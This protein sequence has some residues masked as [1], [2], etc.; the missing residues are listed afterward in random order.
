MTTGMCEGLMIDQRLSDN[1]GKLP[2]VRIAHMHLGKR[3]EMVTELHR[4]CSL[5]CNPRI[6]KDEMLLKSSADPGVI[7]NLYGFIDILKNV[8][9]QFTS[10]SMR[11][12]S[13]L[14]PEE[15]QD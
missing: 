13:F 12:N 1:S 14:I 5:L 4:Q 9:D 15:I 8:C 10:K 3:Y 2:T 6:C 11:A 7:S